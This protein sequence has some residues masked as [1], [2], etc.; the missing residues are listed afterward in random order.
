EGMLIAAGQMLPLSVAVLN[1]GAVW[2]GHVCLGKALWSGPRRRQ[3]PAAA[4]QSSVVRKTAIT[5]AAGSV[6][7]LAA[8]G[9]LAWPQ[10]EAAEKEEPATV[11]TVL[12]PERGD[13][14][15]Q[16]FY[17]VPQKFYE[18]LRRA[19]A[20]SARIPQGWLI[21]KASYQAELH[22]ETPQKE[23]SLKELKATLELRIFTA[24]TV[25][26]PLGDGG[27]QRPVA[28]LLDGAQTP[29]NWAEDGESFSFSVI[30]PGEYRLE[31]SLRLQVRQESE[32]SR[33]SLAIPAVHRATA[34]VQA[35][36]DMSPPTILAAAGEIS[37]AEGGQRTTAWLGPIARFSLE[38]REAGANGS[39]PLWDAEEL[40]WLRVQPGA[41]VLD[42][43]LKVRL[44]SGSLKKFSL[45]ID[46]RWRLLAPVPG[47]A[48]TLR[49]RGSSDA[50]ELVEVTL[51]QA[52][53][54][55]TAVNLRLAP[56]DASGLGHLRLPLLEP[57]GPRNIKK[58]L[59]V[60]IESTATAYREPGEPLEMLAVPDFVDR[61]GP[62][63]TVPQ[64]AYKLPKGP[65]NWVLATA[66]VAP[67]MRVRDSLTNSFGLGRINL[68]YFAELQHSAGPAF[69]YEIEV[70][71]DMT[72]LSLAVQEQG[73]AA[74]VRWSRIAPGRIAVLLHDAAAAE[75]SLEL[76]GWVPCASEGQQPLPQV[77]MARAEA[78]S[79]MVQIFRQPAVLIQVDKL[80]GLKELAEPGGERNASELG[81][82]VGWYEVTAPAY[83]A[84]VSIRV[85]SPI[86]ESTQ[87][88]ILEREDRGNWIAEMRLQVHV[89]DGAIDELHFTVPENWTGPFQLDPPISHQLTDVPGE[90]YRQLFVRPRS[91]IRDTFQLVMRG[92]WQVQPGSRPQ[93]PIL[94]PP[95]QGECDRVVVLPKE[96][97]LQPVDWELRGL[98]PVALPDGLPA[99]IVP[100][101]F[102]AYRIIAEP[103][104]AVLRQ[105]EPESGEPVVHLADIAIRM[106][107][108]GGQLGLAR[109]EL[110]PAGLTVC[111]LVMPT[112]LRLVAC[113][114]AGHTA[115]AVSD[116]PNAWRVPLSSNRLAQRIDVLFASPTPT[117]GPVGDTALAI[118]QLSDW[119]VLRTIYSVE[120]PAGARLLQPLTQ[121]PQDLLQ[122]QSLRL[123][124]T[125]ELVHESARNLTGPMS[126]EAASWRS[127]WLRSLY[128]DWIRLESEAA[129]RAGQGLE[130]PADAELQDLEVLL[131]QAAGR[132]G[133]VWPPASAEMPKQADLPGLWDESAAG[134]G[135]IWRT[136][137]LGTAT[138]G[139]A[140]PPV[141]QGLGRPAR[142]DW[143][144]RLA[145]SIGVALASLI[146]LIFTNIAPRGGHRWLWAVLAGIAWWLWLVPSIVGFVGVLVAIVLFIKHF[147]LSSARIQNPLDM[148]TQT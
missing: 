22:R 50:G 1:S 127:T 93:A 107:A 45:Q 19:A 65:V 72:V 102:Q 11:Y 39:I 95:N 7:I 38:W 124:G 52:V 24:G 118:P 14:E 49:V 140:L 73:V 110:E 132:L 105:P 28:A 94:P 20:E 61:W 111:R 58:F 126:A 10:E 16:I 56:T 120:L 76:R 104:D 92:S 87:V 44:A 81:R 78:A 82:P 37:L 143:L 125:L 121:L 123:Q 51:P 141:V 80:T 4:Q 25:R 18:Q 89:S 71:S 90:S 109:F 147:W 29:I 21:T 55:Q 133:G 130:H 74:N 40:L 2:G 64:M 12:I 13:P 15:E 85:N 119:K 97:A 57:H 33:L 59:A 134:D 47:E 77:R 115:A 41:V 135:L 32:L 67:K 5:F 142:N 137:T 148:R 98:R 128:G 138:I 54:E 96:L 106:N 103:A 113:R 27:G 63:D 144:A 114:V 146:C 34:E 31:I 100:T 66:P 139:T 68:R 36:P 8:G 131:Q 42:A 35:P 79:T 48:A 69:Q 46:P 91:A 117:A 83:A 116:G 60:S 112:G 99:R 75:Q 145:M 53:S 26:I 3:T 108:G 70:P 6:A 86:A 84:V 23:V 122:H 101:A 129:A 43:R 17:R 136:A 30:E 88:T 62:S 9:T